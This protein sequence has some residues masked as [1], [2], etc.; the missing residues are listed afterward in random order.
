MGFVPDFTFPLPVRPTEN[1]GV[2]HQ[3][4]ASCS[5]PTNTNAFPGF[6]V[7]GNITE[8]LRT[9]LRECESY[10]HYIDSATYQ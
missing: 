8:N 9:V 6:D 5:V 1:S 3:Q 2:S 7:E 10:D 4:N